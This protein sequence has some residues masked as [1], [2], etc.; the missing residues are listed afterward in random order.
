MV[1]KILNHP[2]LKTGVEVLVYK[3][4]SVVDA[5]SVYEKT[6][7]ESLKKAGYMISILYPNH[8]LDSEVKYV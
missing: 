4:G 7:N 8:K 1:C 5:F 6:L 3:E 2:R